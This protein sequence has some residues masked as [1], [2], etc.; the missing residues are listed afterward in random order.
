MAEMWFRDPETVVEGTG[1]I[2]LK[3]KIGLNDEYEVL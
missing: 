1:D 2:T 3:F